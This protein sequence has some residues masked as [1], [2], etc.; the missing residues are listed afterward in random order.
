MFKPEGVYVAMVLPFFRDGN[1]N[2]SELKRIIDFNIR[3]GI[4]G[5]FVNSSVGEFI[6]LDFEERKKLTEIVTKYVAKRVPV[7]AGITATSVDRSLQLGRHAEEVG[8]EA[9]VVMPPYFYPTSQEIIERHFEILEEKLNIPIILYNIPMF[10]NVITYDVVKRLSRRP[11]IVG[12]KESSGSMI[13]FMNFLDKIRL[14]GEDQ[15][16]NILV[17][18]EEMFFPTLMVGGKGC[19]TTSAGILPEIIVGIY[20]AWKKEDYDK[21][22]W[23]QFNFLNLFRAMNALP[24][25]IGH[26]VAL[27]VRGFNMGPN[28][29]PL[30]NAEQYNYITVKGRIEKIMYQLLKDKVKV[31]T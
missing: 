7:V 30:S 17:G 4:D 18:R 20:S 31:N 9:V 12:M 13:D 24:F 2:I 6:H 25:P 15:N 16:M 11:G 23:I 14:V 21:A 8:C 3:E 1:I 19:M 5:L 27:E 28:K 29:Q 10:T 22:R 26:K